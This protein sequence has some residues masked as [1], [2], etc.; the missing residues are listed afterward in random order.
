V[1]AKLRLSLI[2]KK[3]ADADPKGLERALEIVRDVVKTDKSPI[4]ALC[5]K[6]GIEAD[7]GD[8]KKALDTFNQVIWKH[9][10]HDLYALLSMGNLYYEKALQS[11]RE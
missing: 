9:S 5:Q 11:A 1:D 3:E 7:I 4:N 6:G 10:H 2:A 8:V